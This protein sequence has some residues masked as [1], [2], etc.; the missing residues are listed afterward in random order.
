MLLMP[1]AFVL[2]R[3]VRKRN[4][5]TISIFIAAQTEKLELM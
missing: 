1:E 5:T 2:D 3:E 4:P